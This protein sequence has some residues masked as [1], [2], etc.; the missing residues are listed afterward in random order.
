MVALGAIHSFNN[1]KNIFKFPEKRGRALFF[2]DHHP[3]FTPGTQMPVTPVRNPMH[4]ILARTDR[5]VGKDQIKFGS[6][7]FK[8][9]AFVNP[10]IPDAVS[11]GISRARESARRLTSVISTCASA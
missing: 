6:D 8:E 4:D 3:E 9:I 5:G 10:D 11:G 2:A 1:R 7:I